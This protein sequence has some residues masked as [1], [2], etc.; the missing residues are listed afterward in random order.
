[1]HVHPQ[2]ITH[3]HTHLHLQSH[4]HACTCCI[5]VTT[6]ASSP[7]VL[8]AETRPTFLSRPATP[9]QRH[10][11][12]S[13]EHAPDATCC[14]RSLSL[15]DQNCWRF[16]RGIARGESAALIFGCGPAP[17]VSPELWRE[18]PSGDV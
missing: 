13:P 3:S 10:H 9:N 14:K 15:R 16:R 12:C 6:A 4:R 7:Q 1:M 2:R 11:T 5:G 17:G 8:A 18:A